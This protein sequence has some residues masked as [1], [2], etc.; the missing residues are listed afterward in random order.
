[1][2]KLDELRAR[3]RERTPKALAQGG[4]W[5]SI[6]AAAPDGTAVVR[7]YD[8]IGF[9][10]T[11]AETFIQE[12]DAITASKIRVEISSPGGD[13]F[14]AV[15]IYNALRLHSAHVTTRVDGIAASAASLIVQAGD[16]RVM[17]SSAQ[18]MVH[19]AWGFAIG[20]ASEMREMA[21]LLE[22][23]DE[24]IAGIYAS[25]AGGDRAEFRALMDAETWLTDEG[26]VEKGL[27]DEVIDPPR[28]EQP[29]D[30]Y[31]G[32]ALHDQIAAA[33]AT[34]SDIVDSAER[35]GALRAEQGKT[36]SQRNLDGLDGLAEVVQ[37]LKALVES[38]PDNGVSEDAS[39]E[40][41]REYARF[42]A[43]TQGV[44]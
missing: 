8:E 30:R 7:I 11:T 38:D 27:A 20:N 24:V 16:H 13:V 3:L 6:Q 22:Q 14:D 5:Y 26:A 2:T 18:M 10:G 19:N 17:V 39:D 31:Q 21:D 34:V 32:P 43:I 36:L 25:R 12:L 37:R 44:N 1:M 41:R 29:A 33:M 9:W 42:V 40:M 15:A 23:Q 4:S 35:V 28:Q